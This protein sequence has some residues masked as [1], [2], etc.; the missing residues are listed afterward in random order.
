MKP[1]LVDNCDTFDHAKSICTKCG[2]S[3]PDVCLE[4][5]QM[6][7]K[8][9]LYDQGVNVIETHGPSAVLPNDTDVDMSDASVPTPKAKPKGR[10]RAKNAAD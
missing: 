1:V 5:E 4:F 2:R 9:E 8:A 3:L 6:K 10:P 7:H